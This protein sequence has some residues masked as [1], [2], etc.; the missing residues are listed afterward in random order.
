MPIRPPAAGTIGTRACWPALT[1]LPLKCHEYPVDLAGRRGKRVF[2]DCCFRCTAFRRCINRTGEQR[3]KTFAWSAM[4][5]VVAGVNAV[6]AASSSVSPVIH[7]DTPVVK[8]MSS[9]GVTTDERG[10]I[11]F[12]APV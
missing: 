1:Q 5:T 12:R 8:V 2:R 9:A 11:G 10:G 3:F 4:K 7:T 6:S